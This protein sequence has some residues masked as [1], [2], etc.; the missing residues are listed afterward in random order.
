MLCAYYHEPLLC[1]RGSPI[2]R[3]GRAV[4]DFAKRYPEFFK[5][6]PQ[7]RGDASDGYTFWLYYFRDYLQDK[8][9]PSSVCPY[10]V[11]PGNDTVC[12]G[13]EAALEKNPIKIKAATMKLRNNYDPEDIKRS[14]V[15]GRAMTFEVE[16]TG[17][18]FYVPCTGAYASR[19]QCQNCSAH[20]PSYLGYKGEYGL[21][22]MSFHDPG[23]RLTN[24]MHTEECCFL[25]T[26]FMTADGAY[27]GHHE[28]SVFGGHALLLVGYNDN[29][30]QPISLS[31]T[32]VRGG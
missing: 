3:Y 14:L 1:S 22:R 23:V 18:N 25:I 21:P 26:G 11:L 9:L 13:Y 5:D 4:I 10:T 31:G 30:Q 16:L 17:S 15:Q 6:T 8:V 29:F 20:C 27:Y 24:G 32:V 12:P 19:P 7:P 2:G 28:Y